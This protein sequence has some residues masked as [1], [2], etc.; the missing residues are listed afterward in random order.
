M[1]ERGIVISRVCCRFLDNPDDVVYPIFLV[2]WDYG[3]DLIKNLAEFCEMRIHGLVIN[4][5]EFLSAS[6]KRVDM[7]LGSI[8]CS[9]RGG[10]PGM[11]ARRQ[12]I[13]SI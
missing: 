7:L 4:E 9:K 6:E 1:G 10:R 5:L 2:L 3:E 11:L 13:L 12:V 8:V